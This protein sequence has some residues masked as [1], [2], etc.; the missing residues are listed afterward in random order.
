MNHF[1]RAFKYSIQGI[2]SCYKTEVAFRQEAHII[3][4]LFPISFLI[5][6]NIYDFLW[7]NLGFCLVLSTELLN[8]SIENTI[9]KTIP[10]QSKKAGMAKDQGS[11]AVF[12]ALCFTGL[13]WLSIIFK[14]YLYQLFFPVSL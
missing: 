10:Q 14:N 5:S 6:S 2:K 13:V 9:D 1:F 12:F 3:M 7:L 11:A 8:T 4:I